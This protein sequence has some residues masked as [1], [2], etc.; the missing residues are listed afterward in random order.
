MAPSLSASAKLQI[1]RPS[2]NSGLT[3]LGDNKVAVL[4]GTQLSINEVFVGPGAG[5]EVIPGLGEVGEVPRRRVYFGSPAWQG[6]EAGLSGL[7]YD[8]AYDVF[9]AV[10]S[11]QPRSVYLLRWDGTG[12]CFSPPRCITA[13]SLAFGLGPLEKAMRGGRYD[14]R[15]P[16]A[17]GCGARAGDHLFQMNTE[18]WGL[19]DAELTGLDFA[20]AT[21]SLYVLAHGSENGMGV[22]TI[23][24][25]TLNA[26]RVG[27][28][29]LE[30]HATAPQVAV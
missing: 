12:R 25:V 29:A 27:F 30:L 23:W 3:W 11:S 5:E 21:R 24:Q 22:T 19:G 26:T 16:I 15:Q 13:G 17:A 1:T 2:E 20:A 8:P 4:D 6:S 7:A 14:G 18:S 10:K 9:Y 28:L